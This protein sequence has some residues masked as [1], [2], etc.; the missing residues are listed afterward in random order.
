[1]PAAAPFA[2][3]SKRAKIE[4]LL[5]AAVLDNH[6]NRNRALRP[7]LRRPVGRGQA[8][9]YDMSVDNDFDGMA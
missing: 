5:V 2:T 7:H 3:P 4:E 1:M 9:I 8:A 6:P